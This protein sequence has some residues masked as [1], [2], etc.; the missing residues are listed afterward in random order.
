MKYRRARTLVFYWHDDELTVENYLAPKQ[1]GQEADNALAIEPLSVEVLHRLGDWVTESDAAAQFPNLPPDSVRET[2]TSLHRAS[3][4]ES[5]ETAFASDRLAKEWAGWGEEARFFHFATRD[6]TYAGVEPDVE[7]EFRRRRR[8]SAGPPPPLFKVYPDAPRVY[9][10]RTFVPLEKRFGDVLAERRTHR[11]FHRDRLDPRVLSTLL[12]HTFS[13]MFL[14]DADVLGTVAM[15]TSPSGGARHEIETY[16]A[17]NAVEAIAPGLYHYAPESH[18]LEL[19]RSDLDEEL[20]S[21]LCYGI[22]MP[23][24]SA[25]VCFLTAVFRRRIWK[26]PHPRNYRVLMLGAGHIGQ[27]FTLVATALGLGAWQTIMFRDSELEAFLGI[28]GY[29]EGALYMVGVGHS[30][31]DSLDL[32]ADFRMAPAVDWSEL[33]APETLPR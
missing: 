15:K 4:L 20:L 9:L 3:L 18:C 25:F 29:A 22:S 30:V 19:L 23:H 21:R 31:T 33:F 6:A 1:N 7:M 13:P 17:V 11:T 10:P 24:D 27:T 8:E 16:V 32:P 28:D 5:E 14:R 2:L 26:Y 12:F